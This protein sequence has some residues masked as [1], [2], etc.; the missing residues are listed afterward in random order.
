MIKKGF[1]TEIVDTVEDVICNRCGKSTRILGIYQYLHFESNWGYSSRR[2]LETWS[3]DLCQDCAEEFEK[4]V[5]KIDKH[6]RE[7]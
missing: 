2:D 4:W 1:S 3:G 5:G 6:D 7:I